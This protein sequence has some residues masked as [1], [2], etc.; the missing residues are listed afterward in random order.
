MQANTGGERV[1]RLTV[2]TDTAVSGAHTWR[3]GERGDAVR[4]YRAATRHSRYVRILRIGV[5]AGALLVATALVLATWFNPL[6]TLA[7]LPKPTGKIVMSG[8]KLT[9]E[10]PKVVGFTRDNRAYEMTAEAA[11][12]DVLK[13][14]IIELSGIRAKIELQQRGIVD[15][16]AVSG[17]YEPRTELLKLHQYIV[18]IS[19][20]GYEGRLTE[21]SVDMRKGYLV[22]EKPV[23]VLM[24][25]GVLNANR[26]EV[27]D[28]G[29]LVRF[30]AGVTMT[31]T[32]SKPSPAAKKAD[33]R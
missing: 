33:D 4:V 25:N 24:L 21:A 7:N 5:P 16:K 23:E 31:M 26:L 10:A 2:A 15:I 17:T 32:P 29:A 12:Q 30:D 19:T 22:S 13:P 27:T 20:T 9:M 18:V 28:N 14:D 8:S 11:S 3:V 1:D 6:R